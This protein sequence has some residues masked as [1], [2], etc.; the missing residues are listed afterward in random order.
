MNKTLNPNIIVKKAGLLEFLRYCFVGGVG[1]M[2]DGGILW[3]L[4]IGY[5]VHDHVNPYFARLVSFSIAVTVT[6]AL[7]RFWTFGGRVHGGKIS[8]IGRQ[9]M[10]YFA[11]QLIAGTVNYGIYAGVIGVYGTAE[12]T[13]MLGFAVGSAIGLFINYVGAKWWIFRRADR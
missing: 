6:W 1:F 4:T 5:L 11:L 7:H 2:V 12:A 8:M 13:I 9:Y 10:G 3:G